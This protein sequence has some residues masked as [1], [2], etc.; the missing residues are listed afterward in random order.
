MK[1]G[2]GVT[3]EKYQRFQVKLGTWGGCETRGIGGAGAPKYNVEGCIVNEID[4]I[5]GA[6]NKRGTLHPILKVD[7]LNKRGK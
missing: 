4:F 7:T 1:S 5:K 6:V 2:R 3:E